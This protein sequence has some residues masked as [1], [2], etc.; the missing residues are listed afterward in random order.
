MQT[1]RLALVGLAM[2]LAGCGGGAYA[3]STHIAQSATDLASWEAC[4]ASPE[5]HCPIPKGTERWRT[6]LEATTPNDFDQW[7]LCEPASFPECFADDASEDHRQTLRLCAA[8]RVVAARS[9]AQTW[10]NDANTRG[11][12]DAAEAMMAYRSSAEQFASTDAPSDPFE[13]AGQ[14]VGFWMAALAALTLIRQMS[15]GQS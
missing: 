2:L 14:R 13:A 8:Q 15:L 9:I 5:L 1:V 6:C 7:E 11:A 3:N 12:K 4:A 10:I